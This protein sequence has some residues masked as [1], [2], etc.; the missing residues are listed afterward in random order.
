MRLK[1]HPKIEER[2]MASTPINYSSIS[3]SEF[4]IETRGSNL[5][6]RIV[7]GF[8]NMWEVRNEHGEKF[9]KGAWTRSI[10][11]NGPK[12]NANYKIKFRD[13]HGRA[14]S[15]FDVLEENSDGLYFRTMPLDKVQWADDAITQIRSGTINNFSNGFK[16]NWAR[17]EWDDSDESLVIIEGRL[18]EISTAYIPSDMETYAKRS[19]AEI[20]K[21]HD[22]VNAI[23]EEF[24]E[25]L[26][27]ARRLEARQIITRHIQLS[28]MSL[29]IEEREQEIEK[30]NKGGIDY[31]Y[32]LTN[33]S[34]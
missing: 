17:T 12:S 28:K 1:S 26:P 11:E 29:G 21:E 13:N 24:I 22:E 23:T 19:F 7:E 33:L 15:L 16:Y 25:S 20:T 30:L 18:L 14:M 32:L 3:F 4:E 8:G 27:A 9:L 31:G 5:D 34:L 10:N 6:K 2:K